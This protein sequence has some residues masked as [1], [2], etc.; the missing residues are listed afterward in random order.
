[1][2]KCC[3]GPGDITSLSILV[4]NLTM[5]RGRRPQIQIIQKDTKPSKVADGVTD[6]L[7]CKNFNALNLFIT[8]FRASDEKSTNACDFGIK[9]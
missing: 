9:I 7:L 1:M 4:S 5:R 6:R 2:W 8:Y 3:V